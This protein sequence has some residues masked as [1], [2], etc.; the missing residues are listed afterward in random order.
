MIKFFLY[1][2][3]FLSLFV[4]NLW[5]QHILRN[6]NR[7]LTDMPFTGRELGKITY[8]NICFLDAPKECAA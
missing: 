3:P 6:N 1:I 5:V 7:V 4:Q 2:L 8:L